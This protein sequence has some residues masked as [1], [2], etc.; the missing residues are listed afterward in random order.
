MEKRKIFA[1]ITLACYAVFLLSGAV[2]AILFYRDLSLLSNKTEGG[3]EAIGAAFGAVVITLLLIL[4]IAYV[5]VSIFPLVM[6]LFHLKTGS[7]V[8]AFICLLFD[9]LYIVLHTILLVSAFAS[10]VALYLV[11]LIFLAL[12]SV[13]ALISDILALKHKEQSEAAS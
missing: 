7:K 2:M 11:V 4:S 1:W 12:L 6:K 3:A 5:V 13:T 10:P 9:A 8:F